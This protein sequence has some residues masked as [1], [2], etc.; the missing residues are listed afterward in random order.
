M[1]LD[2]VMVT[3]LCDPDINVIKERTKKF[4]EKYNKEV[5]LEQDLHRLMDNYFY[6]FK[7]ILKYF[8]T[9]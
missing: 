4:K 6:N 5:A 9:L 1:S 7:I 8:R 2:K 3:A